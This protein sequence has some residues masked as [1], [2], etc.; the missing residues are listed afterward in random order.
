[1]YGVEFAGIAFNVLMVGEVDFDGVLSLRF[2][3]AFGRGL[4]QVKISGYCLP[5]F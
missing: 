5:G 4:S 2:W 1:M 3:R